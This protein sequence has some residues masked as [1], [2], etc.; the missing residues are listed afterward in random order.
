MDFEE[1]TWRWILVGVLSNDAT[2]SY[3]SRYES[4]CQ[5]LGYSDD[6]I[7]ETNRLHSSNP[8]SPDSTFCASDDEGSDSENLS[9]YT[10]RP[11]ANRASSPLRNSPT[12]IDPSSQLDGALNLQEGSRGRRLLPED[13]NLARRD[14]TIPPQ[15]TGSERMRRMIPDRSAKPIGD[16]RAVRRRRPPSADLS[17]SES[18]ITTSIGESAPGTRSTKRPLPDSPTQPDNTTRKGQQARERPGREEMGSPS[19]S[20]MKDSNNRRG[21]WW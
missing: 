13:T 2:R 7:L 18:D 5:A 15:V 12:G 20:G 21:R 9:F 16:P 8:P 10:A 14:A 1:G 19:R 3:R 6:Y 17:P 11:S 4:I